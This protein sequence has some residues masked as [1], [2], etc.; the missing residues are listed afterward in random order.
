MWLVALVGG[1]AWMVRSAVLAQYF[2][3]QGIA[4]SAAPWQ[5]LTV[6]FVIGVG[7][8]P[9]MAW[10][11]A[12]LD[13]FRLE[14]ERLLDEL[15]RREV[16]T[17]E[18]AAYLEA[19]QRELLDRVTEQVHRA[20]G[21]DLMTD[22]DWRDEV[23]AASI[24]AL[25]SAMQR[26]SRD[27]AR[28][29]WTQARASSR[30]R[31]G[32]VLNAAV[33]RPFSYWP[34]P[35]FLLT[36]VLVLERF[37]DWRATLLLFTVATGWVLAVSFIGNRLSARA[38]R[39]SFIRYAL[40]LAVQLA[41]G[42][43]ATVCLAAVRGPDP[44]YPRLALTL[45]FWFTFYVA[46]GGLARAVNVAE[47]GVLR[48]MELSIA[49]A[50][51]QARALEVEEARLRSAIATHLHG[52][53]A[54]NVTAALMRLRQAMTEGDVEGARQA[55]ADARGQLRVD[56]AAPLLDE[57][58]DLSGLLAELAESWAGI[59]DVSVEL[60]AVPSLSTRRVR[61]VV[62]LVTEAVNNAVRHGDARLIGIRVA[63]DDAHKLRIEVLDDG[64]R[65]DVVGH[66]LGSRLLDRVATGGWS[67]ES[68]AGGG[69]NLTAFM[70]LEP[71]GPNGH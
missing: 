19:M 63:A 2:S 44:E 49:S 24:E 43:V 26:T 11:L 47:A 65:S 56:V 68:R 13:D 45:G 4:T 33:L 62:D 41:N 35:L 39:P 36:G 14:R 57:R 34:I 46:L 64:T 3:W 1:I 30:I 7:L 10:V 27:L 70:R 5:R 60:V 31:L 12:T 67:R 32:D 53:V 42:V 69:T 59:A 9:G 23:G 58:G 6:G 50:E 8:V 48:D 15:V 38:Q 22:T 17:E 66:G 29:V 37:V 18:S 52:T 55:Y 16:A 61:D 21:T 71:E 20:V 28:A 51:I 40:L 54:A 25:E